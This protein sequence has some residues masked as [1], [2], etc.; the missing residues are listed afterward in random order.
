MRPRISVCNLG[1][2]DLARSRRFYEGLGF[3]ARP[4]SSERA[5]F[6]ELEWSWLSLFTRER[7][8]GLCGQAPEGSGFPGFC[9]SHN[10]TT[11]E[12]VDAVLAAAVS[13]GGSVA[14]PAADGSY[15]R[16]GYFA[17]PDGF[18][19]EVAYTPKWHE[20]TA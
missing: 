19:W 7:L 17:D 6:F 11:A 10:V 16:I 4:E 12:E 9:F 1:V 13:L 8:A 18:R 20:L 15:G 5:V 14:Q 2:S 3:V